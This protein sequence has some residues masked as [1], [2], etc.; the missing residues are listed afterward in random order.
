V[1]ATIPSSDQH[2]YGK[3]DIVTC[4]ECGESFVCLC[5]RAAECPCAQV[6]LSRDESEWIGWQTGNECVCQ[7]CLLR[8]RDAARLVLD[9]ATPAPLV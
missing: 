4:N 9:P 6:C 8:F 5:N 2:N 7:T 1:D 3:H